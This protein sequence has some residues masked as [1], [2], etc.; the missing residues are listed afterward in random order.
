MKFSIEPRAGYL[1]AVVYG[2]DTA[3]QM[4]EFLLAVHAACCKHR[5]TKILMSVRQSRAVF[6]P[7]EWGL[8]GAMRAS[9]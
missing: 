6:K 1:H 7:E 3:E 5:T 8:S 9:C 4:R 2:R